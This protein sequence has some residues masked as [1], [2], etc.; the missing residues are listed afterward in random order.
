VDLPID[1]IVAV[2]QGMK[3]DLQREANRAVL[4]NDLNRA[5]GAL[6]TINGIDDLV[7]RLK[8]RSGSQL[9]LSKHPFTRMTGDHRPPRKHPSI[10]KVERKDGTDEAERAREDFL[11]AN[12]RGA[13]NKSRTI[14]N[15][16]SGDR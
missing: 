3:E 14:R 4:R 15:G 5:L 16:H 12:G 2:A 7:Y 10:P 8:I 1:A 13:G 9:G 11:R 6:A